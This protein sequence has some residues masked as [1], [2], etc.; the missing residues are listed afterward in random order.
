MGLKFNSILIIVQYVSNFFEICFR[1]MD[2]RLAA[3]FLKM[4]RCFVL[5]KI[6]VVFLFVGVLKSRVLDRDSVDQR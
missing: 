5:D 3:F 2:E 4:G 6:F 1:F